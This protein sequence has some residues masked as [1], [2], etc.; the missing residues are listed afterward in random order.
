[1]EFKKGTV[2][3]IAE[4]AIIAQGIW[5]EFMHDKKLCECFHLRPT[6]SAI[7]VISTLPYAPM[8]GIPVTP[9][10]LKNKLEE[11]AA[12]TDV[13]LGVDVNKSLNLMEKWGFKNREIKSKKS[14]G[15]IEENAQAFF[16]NGMIMGQDMYEGINFVASELVLADKSSR[17]DIVGYK[18]GT[19]FI[20]EMKKDRTLAGLTQTAG[21]ADLIKKNKKTFLKVLKNYPHNPVDDFKNIAAIAV[22][23]Y[24][25]NS[26]TLLENRAREA[27]VG[28]WFFERSIALRKISV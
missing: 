9:N 13:L 28:L 25:T 27:G 26:A 20:F 5:N 6:A 16:I 15:F 8:R 7:A 11:I 21:Y 4:N 2:N 3:R 14:D 22:M 18:N 12:K 23:R 19:L 10:K 1:M 17:F 24:A